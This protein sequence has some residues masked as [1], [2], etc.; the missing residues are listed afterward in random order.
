MTNCRNYFAL[1]DDGG[2]VVCTRMEFTQNSLLVK[3]LADKRRKTGGQL[4]CRRFPR[5]IWPLIPA[6]GMEIENVS[7]TIPRVSDRGN[8]LSR[9]RERK[10]T[11]KI[12]FANF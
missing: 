3:D 9:N 1:L 10:A 6:S 4:L 5:T 11:Q 8:A 7:E 2:A 12:Q